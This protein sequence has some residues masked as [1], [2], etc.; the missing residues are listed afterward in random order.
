[1]L[2]L[3]TNRGDCVEFKT[4]L[5]NIRK[6]KNLSMRKVEELTGISQA[7][8]SQ[9]ESGKRGTPT[10]NIL[11]K[12]SKGLE[13]DYIQLLQAAGYVND[14]EKLKQIAKTFKES[15][16]ETMMHTV[17]FT[18]EN[19]IINPEAFP[20]PTT[21][22]KKIN[23]PMEFKLDDEMKI[24]ENNDILN[25]YNFISLSI[26]KNELFPLTNKT[27][28]QITK[29]DLEKILSIIDTILE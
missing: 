10:P 18:D 25:L 14:A 23:V 15:N 2:T 27:G 24:F 28:E 16:E 12:L 8:L 19:E 5:K 21:L 7:Y 6:E 17:H 29:G 4:Y 9:I 1:M 13:T 22:Q 3:V 11:K 26:D 20:Q